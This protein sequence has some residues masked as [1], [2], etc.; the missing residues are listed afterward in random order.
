MRS[1]TLTTKSCSEPGTAAPTA[2]PLM[3]PVPAPGYCSLLVGGVVLPAPVST[4]R[5]GVQAPSAATARPTAARRTRGEVLIME[6]YPCSGGRSLSFALK[7]LFGP[8]WPV[9]SRDNKGL[10]RRE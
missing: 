6:V 3:G 9:N 4:G 5:R 10:T 1:P 7:G 8:G 2:P